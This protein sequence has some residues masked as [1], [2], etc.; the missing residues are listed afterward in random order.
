MFFIEHGSLITEPISQLFDDLLL[1][2]FFCVKINN[3]MEFILCDSEINNR[4]KFRVLVDGIDTTQFDRNPVMLYDHR[5]FGKEDM[6]IGK[7]DN[8]RKEDGVIYGTPDFDMNDDFA[9]KIKSK[10]DGGYIRMASVGLIPVEWSEDSQY[11]L[12]GQIGPTLVK[13]ILREVSI[14]PF[15][16]NWNALKLCDNDG[17]LI[18]LSEYNFDN[19]SNQNSDTMSDMKTIAAALNLSDSASTSE[20]IQKVLNLSEANKTLTTERDGYKTRAEAAELKLAD[21]AKEVLLSEAVK[22]KRI[23]EKEKAVLLKLD[24][25]DLKVA[26]S[27]RKPADNLPNIPSRETPSAD[28]PLL[29]MSWGELDRQGKLT[30]LKDKHFEAF[31]E[32][33]KTQF[34]RDY[35]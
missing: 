16:A 11:K 8:C 30:E 20:I 6:P 12:E 14:T 21:S 5:D 23:T 22:D 24:I 31:K 19:I 15:G 25:E 33:F 35:E 2:E 32:K 29:K 7:W 28:D 26:L 4:F 1:S 10:V 18:N 3:A 34:G 13:S 27:E 9:K 17:K